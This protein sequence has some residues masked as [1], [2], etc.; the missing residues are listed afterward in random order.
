MNNQDIDAAMIP[1]AATATMAPAAVAEVAITRPSPGIDNP[2]P[3]KKLKIAPF[4]S[5]PEIDNAPSPKEKP[6]EFQRLL[7]VPPGEV[8]PGVALPSVGVAGKPKEDDDVEDDSEPEVVDLTG[9]DDVPARASSGAPIN[10]YHQFLAS[11]RT[12]SGKPQKANATQKKRDC[13]IMSLLSKKLYK[14]GDKLNDLVATASE[15]I[16]DEELGRDVPLWES[17]RALSESVYESATELEL[18]FKSKTSK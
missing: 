3:S 4:A 15:L 2:S 10:A 13:E 12:G 17:L 16:E 14:I 1:V 8:H 6:S 9:D 11:F 18:E 7:A 5:A